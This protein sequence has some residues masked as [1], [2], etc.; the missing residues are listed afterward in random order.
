MKKSQTTRKEA[1]RMNSESSP[2]HIC[3]LPAVLAAASLLVCACVA[4]RVPDPTATLAQHKQ[5]PVCALTFDDGPGRHT[6]Q[7]LDALR[8]RNAHATFF[9][10]GE[11]VRREPQVVRLIAAEGHEVDNHSFDHPD[12]RHLSREDQQREIDATQT[13][14][15]SLGIEP[16]F[17]R[18][19]Y[20][21]Y[22]VDTV[23]AAARDGLVV[24]LWTTDGKDWKYHTVHA[25][26]ANVE[27]ELKVNIGGIY[28]FHDVHAWTVDAMPSILDRMAAQG[29]RFVTLS[30]YLAGQPEAATARPQG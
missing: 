14:L 17:F 16:K 8:S 23:R 11:Q 1:G 19:P 30:E 2:K 9:V 20:G 28:L 12:F 24:V 3:P 21:D 22:D 27:R 6:V 5:Q 29:C 18:P 13:A 7:L 4:T 25:L 15:R 26:E 10:L